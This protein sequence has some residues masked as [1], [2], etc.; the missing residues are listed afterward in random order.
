MPGL[1]PAGAGARATRY[2]RPPSFTPDTYRTASTAKG[3]NAGCSGKSF[4]AR[5]K[6]D[7][8][9]TIFPAPSRRSRGA[10]ADGQPG[11]TARGGAERLPGVAIETTRREEHDR[12]VQLEIARRHRRQR[13]PRDQPQREAAAG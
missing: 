11:P 3:T 9:R 7:A 13:G 10:G 4:Q 2:S 1:A 8:N 6:S 12:A 5:S